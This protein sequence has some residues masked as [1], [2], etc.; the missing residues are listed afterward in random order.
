MKSIQKTEVMLLNVR[1]LLPAIRPTN[2]KHMGPVF[3]HN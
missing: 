2:T 3:P 1:C